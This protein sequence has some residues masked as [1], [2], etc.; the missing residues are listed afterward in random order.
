CDCSRLMKNNL[1]MYMIYKVF[2]FRTKN[3]KTE[4]FFI[5]FIQSLIAHSFT[6]TT[7]ALIQPTS[8][9]PGRSA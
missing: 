7:N 9:R 2:I 3:P 4:S 5:W 1:Y 8:Y 6:K